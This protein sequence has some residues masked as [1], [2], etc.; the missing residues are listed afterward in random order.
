MIR[1]RQARWSGGRLPLLLLLVSRFVLGIGYSLIVPIWEAYDEDGHFAY[2][3]YLARY[4]HLLLPGDPEAERVWERF[5]PPLYYLLIA[6][7]V[8]W[9]DVGETFK[10]PQLNANFA[11]GDAGV[12]YALHPDHLDGPDSQIAQAVHAARVVGVFITTVGVLFVYLAAVQ[13]WPA[14][15]ATRWAVT[16]LY[17]FWPQLL[18][19]GSVIT[20]D[21]LVATIG[22]GVF[23]VSVLLLSKGFRVWRAVALAGLLAA[24]ILTKINA[25][26]ILPTALLAAAVSLAPVVRRGGRK[27]SYLWLALLMLVGLIAVAIGLL[28]SMKLVT[29]QVLRLETLS[30]FAANLAGAARPIGPG[31]NSITL[32]LRYGFRTFFASFGWGNLETYPWAY[33]LWTW[34]AG[35]AVAGLVLRV[36]RG[37]RGAGRDPKLLLFWLMGLQLVITVGIALALVIAGNNI[38]LLP[39][40][41]L[42]PVLPQVCVLL[43]SGWSVL[44]P[45]R[46]QAG[47]W[48]GLS[49]GIILLGWSIPIW[50]IAPA[51][52]K[53]LPQTRP[54]DVAVTYHLGESIELLGYN[55]PPLVRPGQTATVRLCWQAI[56]PVKLNAT[57]FLEIIGPDGQG[58]GRLATYPGHG[59]YATSLWTLGVPF[60]DNYAVPV[61]ADFPAPAVAQL[62][63]ALLTTADVNGERLLVVAADGQV[64]AGS[65]VSLPLTVVPVRPPAPL[66]HTVNVRFGDILALRGYSLTE[67]PAAHAVRVDLR[68]EALR[69]LSTDYMIFVHLRDMPDH[70]YAQGDSEPRAGWYPTHLWQKGETV[71][72]EHVLRL[73]AGPPPPLMLYVGV[74]DPLANNRL[75]AFDVGGQR[76]AN[77]EVIL[78]RNLNLSVGLSSP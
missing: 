19:N 22:A 5:Q 16:S 46:W 11:N 42:L 32:A 49:V 44:I 41:Y 76:L 9:F 73:P 34:G 48:K 74:V 53:P 31:S 20:N 71:L 10:P 35:L 43:V 61:G 64:V 8:A 14:Q 28:G 66:A 62:R 13:L 56:A 4:H 36:L 67:V 2:A 12:N 78:D 3:R 33:D 55:R 1:A 7:V 50:T 60:C 65:A 6:P 58:Y 51:Y 52:A 29:S 37:R 23:Y 26:A 70:A 21:L 68:W 25:L 30:N 17:A 54:A 38:F 69:D 57:V 77:D 40:R 47:A 72:D 59:N 45:R 63:V 75:P 27:P 18:F 15:R 39:G 24:G